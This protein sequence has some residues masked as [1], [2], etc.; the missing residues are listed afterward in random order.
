MSWQGGCWEVTSLS[1]F[2]VWNVWCSWVSAQGLLIEGQTP[3]TRSFSITVIFLDQRTWAH[4]GEFF[5]LSVLDRSEFGLVEYGSRLRHLELIVSL[6]LLWFATLTLYFTLGS[7]CGIY[8]G[9][10]LPS[11][12]IL[13]RGRPAMV[14]IDNADSEDG[15]TSAIG[16]RTPVFMCMLPFSTCFHLHYF[17]IYDWYS[18]LSKK[19]HSQNR[20]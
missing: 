15:D 12:L 2:S 18:F 3:L 17:H 4:K 14:D 11:V 8:P 6:K 9:M 7:C 20:F 10:S 19:L 5:L 1:L 16:I 13:P